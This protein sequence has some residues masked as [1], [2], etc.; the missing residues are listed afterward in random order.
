MLEKYVLSIRRE[1]GASA[2]DCNPSYL[3]GRDH[4]GLR[5]E[6]RPGKQVERPYL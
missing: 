6:A 4:E 3:G 1:P 2:Y 5:L